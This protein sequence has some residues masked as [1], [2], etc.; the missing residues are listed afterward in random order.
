MVSGN[1]Q[2]L[3]TIDDVGTTHIELVN[4]AMLCFVL[5]NSQPTRTSMES[6]RYNILKKKKKRNLQTMVLP[7]NICES[8]AT[9]HTWAHLQDMSCSGKQRRL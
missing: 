6:A 1:F 8:Y 2:D 3:A 5:L 9:Q 4:A 7:Q